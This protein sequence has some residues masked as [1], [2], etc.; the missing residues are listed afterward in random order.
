MN[1]KQAFTLAEILITLG[2]IGVVAAITLP[3]LITNLNERINS[4]REANIAQ[5]MTQ[6]M[7]R[8]RAQGLLNTQYASTDAFVDELQNYLKISKR[9]NAE[10]MENCWPTKKVTTSSGEE[11]EVK[12][13]KKGKDINVKAN[14]SDNVGLVLADGAAL[15]LTYNNTNAQTFDI[16]EGV[17]V[18]HEVL[19]PIGNGKKKSFPYTTGVTGSIAFVMDVNGAKGPNSETIGER[20][21]DIRGFNGASFSKS[22]DFEAGGLCIKKLDSTYNWEGAKNA[23]EGIDMTLTSR[24]NLSTLYALK[25]TVEGIPNSGVYWALDETSE[26]GPFAYTRDFGYS[27]NDTSYDGKTGM[28]GAMCV[29]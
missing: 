27:M 8:M 7:E 23:C 25:D 11:Y 6:A 18:E 21:Y 10:N 2:V 22:C 13:A 5:K 16:G 29:E 1:N 24:A 15:I 20:A 4:E 17:S 28:H 3:P 9:C 26:K 12:K 14:T 19:L